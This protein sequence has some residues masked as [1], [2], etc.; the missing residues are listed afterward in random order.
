MPSQYDIDT[1]FLEMLLSICFTIA[2]FSLAFL[3]SLI[4]TGVGIKLIQ[5]L[6]VLFLI[7]FTLFLGAT[8]FVFIAWYGKYRTSFFKF[9]K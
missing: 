6:Y 7:L 2:I 9:R 4:P 3:V 1:K 8:F 5:Q